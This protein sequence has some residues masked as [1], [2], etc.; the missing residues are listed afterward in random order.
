MVNLKKVA[1][2]G[3]LVLMMAAVLAGCQA[4]PEPSTATQEPPE[5]LE[6]TESASATQSTEPD[7]VAS[8]QDSDYSFVLPEYASMQSGE[9]QEVALEDYLPS[10]DMVISYNRPTHEAGGYFFDIRVSDGVANYVA[11]S[12]PDGG[13]EGTT[14][15][16]VAGRYSYDPVTGC[17][18]DA[19]AENLDLKTPYAGPV[20]EV[21]GATESL[22]IETMPRLFRVLTDAGI[23]DDC[24]AVR[25]V[26]TGENGST[27]HAVAFYAPGIGNV[28][29]EVDYGIGSADYRVSLVASRIDLMAGALAT[30]VAPAAAVD[31]PAPSVEPDAQPVQDTQGAD[32]APV[33][34]GSGQGASTSG[35]GSGHHQER[36]GWHHG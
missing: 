33:S 17:L 16:V 1:R 8:V 34:P 7:G 4:A 35:N 30:D 28:L 32:A 11:E 20:G 36:H 19:P 21:I 14:S 10:E 15:A 27:V 23:F 2:T 22:A 18:V 25:E 29:R 31:E 12:V 5:G 9:G 6:A 26:E 24:I 3:I 13:N